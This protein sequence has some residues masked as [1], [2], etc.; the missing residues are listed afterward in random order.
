MQIFIE[1][2]QGYTVVVNV[3][4]THTIGQVKQQLQLITGIPAEMQ[5]III[6]RQSLR[7]DTFVSDHDFVNAGS[8]SLIHV[9][10]AI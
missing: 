9:I 2:P 8:V 7:N 5:K 6:N 3:E 1:I 10:R 4:P